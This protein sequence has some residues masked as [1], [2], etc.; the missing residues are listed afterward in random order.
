MSER[1]IIKNFAGIKKLELDV[2][3][4]TIL[5]GPQTTGKSV[6]AKLLFFFKNFINEMLKYDQQDSINFDSLMLNKFKKYFPPESLSKDPFSIR[7][8]YNDEFIEIEGIRLELK[9]KYSREYANAVKNFKKQLKTS[10]RK[11]GVD[12]SEISQ[13]VPNRKE[14]MENSKKKIGNESTFKQIFIP[15]GR[16]FFAILERNIFS[17]LSENRSIDPFLVEFGF[18]YEITKA[19]MEIDPETDTNNIQAKF[20]GIIENFIGGKYFKRE[21]DYIASNDGRLTTVANSSS[22]QQAI[23]P[24]VIILASLPFSLWLGG[25]QSVYVEE[26]EAHLF[27]TTQRD[28]VELIALVY[29]SAMSPSQFFITTHSPYILT[30]FNNLLQA[31]FI[32]SKLSVRKKKKLYEIVPR[33]RILKPG[34][35]IAYSL[36]DGGGHCILDSDG[37]ITTNIIDDVSNELSKQFGDLLDIEM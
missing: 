2:R 29:N 4:I 24:L 11:A 36:S 3:Q 6:C 17:L 16:S 23:L 15:A 10:K 20:D 1:L 5:I 26:P 13:Y 21:T 7:Y 32:E 14:L 25:G 9:L 22:G 19:S 12:R 33:E 31:G 35:V 18:I 34:N 27:P 37:L 28:I 8:E 30:A